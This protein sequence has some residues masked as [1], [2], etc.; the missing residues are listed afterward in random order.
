MARGLRPPALEMLGLGAAVESYVRSVAD[1]AGIEALVHAENVAGLLSAES[2]L[3]LYRIVQESVSNVIRHSG[4]SR[5]SVALRRRGP[6]VDVTI[7]DDGSGFDPP[8]VMNGDR[9][10]GLFGM[11]ERAA[12]MGGRLEIDSTRGTGTRVQVSVPATTEKIV[13]AG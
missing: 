4:A 2:E 11:K 3:A 12:I 8:R 7:E 9:G 6:G 1:A 5:V 10:L 13:H